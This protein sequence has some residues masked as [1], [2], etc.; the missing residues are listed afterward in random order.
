[1]MKKIALNMVMAALVVAGCGD[2]GTGPMGN[3]DGSALPPDDCSTGDSY[4]YVV[5]ILD[6][7][8]EMDGVS[9]GYNLD[10]RVSDVTDDLGCN[11]DDFTSPDGVEGVDNAMAILL[12]ILGT[13]AGDISGTIQEGVNDGSILVLVEMTHVNDFTNDACVGMNLYVG[14]VPGDLAPMLADGLLAPG[15][16]F[17]I[18]PE[19]LNAMGDPVVSVSSATISGGRLAASPEV[20]SLP[21]PLSDG[22]VLQLNIRNPRVG[23]TFTA[24]TMQDGIIAGVLSS[25]E[26]AQSVEAL[27]IGG[28]D[29][30]TVEGILVG[31]ADMQDAM[32]ECTSLSA[33]LTYS[34]V[35]AVRGVVAP[36]S[37]SM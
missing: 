1:M 17:D 35:D 8:K 20:I 37:G 10:D 26:L 6:I 3:P 23:G 27:D 2:D 15:Q 16:T 19:S 22:I 30:A 36:A 21:V 28:V 4:F 31:Q 24:T 11:K 13:I 7:A 14:E 32:G 9:A 34:G 29:A 18:N 25:A 33:T 12:P 5:N